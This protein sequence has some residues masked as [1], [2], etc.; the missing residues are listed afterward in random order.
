MS[1]KHSKAAVA[2]AA[3]ST[4]GLVVAAMAAIAS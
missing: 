3:A 1:R 2:S 4:E